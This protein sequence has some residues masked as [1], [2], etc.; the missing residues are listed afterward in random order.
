MS[1]QLEPRPGAA[2]ESCPEAARI[3]HL[4]DEQTAGRKQLENAPYRR[5]LSRH[6]LEDVEG[7]HAV[8]LGPRER[9]PEEIA[10]VDALAEAAGLLRRGLV[11]LDPGHL[12][13]ERLRDSQ[14]RTRAA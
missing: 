14:R 6:V 9:R 12:P 13:A 11:H 4:H 1:R 7:G 8:E 2:E 3:G 10:R 5:D